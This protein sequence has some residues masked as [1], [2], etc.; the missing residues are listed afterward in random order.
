M[1]AKSIN[2]DIGNILQPKELKGS[3]KLI[4]DAAQDLNSV[5]I[6]THNI[7]SRQNHGFYFNITDRDNYY[8]YKSIIEI[9]YYTNGYEED[10]IPSNTWELWNPNVKGE[11]TQYFDEWN[12]LFLTIL[13]FLHPN[14]YEEYDKAKDLLNDERKTIVKLEKRIEKLDKIKNILNAS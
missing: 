11:T 14:I 12:E 1:R 6:E 9:S 13:K 3:E 5:G 4:Y 2:E 8:D 10:N 7:R